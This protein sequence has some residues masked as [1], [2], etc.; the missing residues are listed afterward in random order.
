MPTEARVVGRAA[1]AGRAGRFGGAGRA[2]AGS[3]TEVVGYP[4]DPGRAG[5]ASRV[6]AGPIRRPGPRGSR[7][8]EVRWGTVRRELRGR[9]H[10]VSVVAVAVAVVVAVSLVAASAAA[11]WPAHMG[12]VSARREERRWSAPLPV[13]PP[14]PVRRSGRRRRVHW[15]RSDL[16]PLVARRSLSGA[17][18]DGIG[19]WSLA[20]VLHRME[21]SCQSR[22]R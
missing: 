14:D 7:L 17:P 1:A 13:E 22:T 8:S 10:A 2:L 6:V 15:C 4:W 3:S 9:P 11:A 21:K 16:V 20:T 12:V 19:S 5:S 18:V